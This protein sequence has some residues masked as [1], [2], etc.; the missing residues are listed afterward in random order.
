MKNRVNAALYKKRFIT[1]NQGKL[2][3]KYVACFILSFLATLSFLSMQAIAQN[4]TIAGEITTPYPTIVNLAIE[5]KIQ[6]DE[7]HNGVVSVKFREKG[8][9][10]WEEGMPLR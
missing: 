3:L 5:W 10:T 2:S 7:N 6:G 1:K 9:P 8:K 4:E